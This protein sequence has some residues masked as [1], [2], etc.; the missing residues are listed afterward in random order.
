MVSKHWRP[1]SRADGNLHDKSCRSLRSKELRSKLRCS[2]E[3]PR[4]F[5]GIH[6]RRCCCH[7]YRCYCCASQREID[8]G[9]ESIQNKRNAS[10]G[11]KGFWVVSCL[12]ASI[13]VIHI[14][15]ELHQAGWF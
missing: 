4:D 10:Y 8:Q 14:L 2:S 9:T 6:E 15:M 5:G 13:N 12:T 7:Q 11:H 1:G 3:R